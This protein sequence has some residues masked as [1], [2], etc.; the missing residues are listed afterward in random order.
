LIWAVVS[1][2][3]FLSCQTAAEPGQSNLKE[4]MRN[5]E[6]QEKILP[7]IKSV[8]E[9]GDIVFRMGTDITSYMFAE[10]NEKDKRFSHC[11]IA[12]LEDGK[13]YIYHSLGGEFNPDQTM[14]KEPIEWF[15]AP[16]ESKNL[17]IFSPALKSLQKNK[18]LSVVRGWY[19]MEIPFDMQ[20]DLATN[21]R[22]Y[23]AEMVT[24]AL[25]AGTGNADWVHIS[26]RGNLN[27]IDT[28]DLTS[29]TILM[30]KGFWH[31]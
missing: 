15:A 22:M 21:D 20:F 31:Y 18:M 3:A 29:N 6:F 23:C 13:W 1:A 19:A 14:L 7:E 24:K 16:G 17:G 5:L 26:R 11:G 8:L 30:E 27:Y 25:V 2:T 9:P 12:N 4:E 10:L 28:E